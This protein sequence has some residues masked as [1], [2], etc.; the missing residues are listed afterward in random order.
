[1]RFSRGGAFA[2]GVVFAVVIGGGTAVATNGGSLLIG[3]GNSATAT[4]GLA[5]SKGTPLSLSAKKGTPPLKVSNTVKV[6]NLDSDLLDGKDSKA[7]LGKTSQAADSAK[8]GGQPASNYLS[9]TGTAAD[10]A[11]LGGT[12]AS[13]YLTTSGTAA[14][15]AKLGG[16]PASSYVGTVYAAQTFYY[17][18]PLPSVYSSTQFD[19]ISLPAGSYLVALVADL[20]NTDNVNGEFGC[21]VQ[22][23]VGTT[24]IEGE[25][26]NASINPSASV[27]FAAT[28]VNQVITLPAAGSVYAYCYANAGNPSHNAY[29]YNSTL[30]ATRIQSLNGSVP[31]V[32]QHSKPTAGQPAVKH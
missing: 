29:V 2:S 9:T 6:K 20:A 15:S 23:A 28:A 3:K 12:P 14:N 18:S 22:A 26:G 17:T 1:M 24:F 8:L 4:T 21:H 7:F 13:G 32:L 10:S 25:Y 27:T 5:N 30:T 16:L 31:L 19:N 11:K